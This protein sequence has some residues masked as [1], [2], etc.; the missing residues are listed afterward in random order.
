MVDVVESGAY[1][2]P[3]GGSD[4]FVVGSRSLAGGISIVV[5]QSPHRSPTRQ[6]LEEEL[7]TRLLMEDDLEVN[8]VQHLPDLEADD[9][10]LLCLQGIMAHM[11]LAAWLP[12]QESFRAAARL[13]I[14]GRFGMTRHAPALPPELAD[15]A[16][17][18]HPRAI[19]CL[20]LSRFD[21]TDACRDEI[22]RIR[23]ERSVQVFQLGGLGPRRE[24]PT[25]LAPLADAAP[26]SQS[27]PEQPPKVEPHTNS[28]SATSSSSP[29]NGRRVADSDE[30]EVESRLDQLV[31]E[32]D[33]LDL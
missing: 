4:L 10:G 26:P 31:D 23:D 3:A 27:K 12:P 16:P 14:A 1:D 5:S 29:D 17:V 30:D 11:V 2:S 24:R 28:Q 9:T 21:N 18:D 13:G 20:D 6:R 25:P 22:R 32:L 19:Y 8:V 33:G 7:V 15:L